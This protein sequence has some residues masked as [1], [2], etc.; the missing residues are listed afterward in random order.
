MQKSI[1]THTHSMA[2]T[3]IKA[4]TALTIGAVPLSGSVLPKGEVTLVLRNSV[5]TL[6]KCYPLQELPLDSACSEARVKAVSR[7]LEKGAD[8][9]PLTLKNCIELFPYE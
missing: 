7:L 5:L 8:V 9:G 4:Y 1:C 3:W 6:A 2:E